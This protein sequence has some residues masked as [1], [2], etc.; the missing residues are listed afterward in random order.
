MRP[1]SWPP[2]A[3]PAAACLAAGVLA[4][5]LYRLGAGGDFIFDDWSNLS[6]LGALGGVDSAETFWLYLLSGISGPT[7]RPVAAASFLLDANN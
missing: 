5:L 4:Y 7:G 2:T 3:L 6:L 1:A